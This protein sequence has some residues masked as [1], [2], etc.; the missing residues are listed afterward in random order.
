M[1]IYVGL[2]INVSKVSCVE[3]KEEA[4]GQSRSFKAIKRPMLPRVGQEHG[5][6]DC[7]V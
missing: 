6:V 4:K 7:I 5:M 2:H 3:K 1:A